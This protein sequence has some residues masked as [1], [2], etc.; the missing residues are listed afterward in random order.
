MK[1]IVYFVLCCFSMVSCLTP[2]KGKISAQP[3]FQLGENG[4]FGYRIPSIISVGEGKLVAFAEGRKE[5]LSDA[6]RIDLVSKRSDD[7]G[8]TWSEMIV[9]W[10]DGANTCGNPCPVFIEDE[11]KIVLLSTWNNSRDR[12]GQIWAK[13]SIDTRRVFVLESLDLGLTWSEPREITDMAKRPEWGWYATGPGVGIILQHGQNKGRIIIPSDHSDGT[14]ANSHLIYSDD[15]GKTWEIGAIVGPGSNECQAVEL[16]NGDIILNMRRANPFDQPVRLQA[17]SKDGGL[18]FEDGEFGKINLTKDIDPR[19]Q[20]G[21]VRRGG[22][23]VFSNANSTKR[24]NMTVKLSYTNDTNWDKIIPVFAG[25]SA[26]SCPVID[27]SGRIGLLFEAGGTFRYEGIWF[28][29]IPNEKAI[30]SEDNNS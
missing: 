29:E 10:S 27:K 16:D 17:I 7:F 21:F 20:A 23:I 14:N 4:Y 12:E 13:Q 11:Q 19:C 8:K 30:V 1:K 22:L 25:P 28:A 15:N 18:S 5:S 9:V 2:V 3:I 26:Y 24:K 6:G